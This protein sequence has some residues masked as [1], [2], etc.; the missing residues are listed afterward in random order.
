MNLINNRGRG[1]APMIAQH[2][3]VFLSLSWQQ[4]E[5]VTDHP[6]L[7]LPENHAGESCFNSADFTRNR[8][9]SFRVLTS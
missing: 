6:L 4:K 5:G 1:N 3:C 2:I 7:T 9:T 8:Q